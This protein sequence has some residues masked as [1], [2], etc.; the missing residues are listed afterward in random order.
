M[1]LAAAALGISSEMSP[2]ILSSTWWLYWGGFLFP[3]VSSK[4]PLLIESGIAL[5]KFWRSVG[6]AL[7]SKVNFGKYRCALSNMLGS[8]QSFW[9]SCCLALATGSQL[10]GDVL[11]P[12]VKP[13]LI[14]RV[15]LEIALCIATKLGLYLILGNAHWTSSSLVCRS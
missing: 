5:V 6:D 15:L 4:T 12:N 3:V 8:A 10:D 11:S 9:A 2:Y 1:I 7:S 13:V 14:M